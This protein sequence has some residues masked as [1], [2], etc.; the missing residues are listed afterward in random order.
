MD[1]PNNLFVGCDYELDIA[2][3]PTSEFTDP[4]KER[5]MDSHARSQFR[6]TMSHLDG[7]YNKVVETD[8][9]EDEVIDCR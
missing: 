8:I 6:T 4:E 7:L 5:E 1:L 9:R 2:L 3:I